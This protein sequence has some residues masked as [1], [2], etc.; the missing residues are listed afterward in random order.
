ML[1]TSTSY[2]GRTTDIPP[3]GSERPTRPFVFSHPRAPVPAMPNTQ[4]LT[5][6]P[7]LLEGMPQ[8]LVDFLLETC[9][10]LATGVAFERVLPLPSGQAMVSLR[11][12]DTQRHVL[13][14]THQGQVVY[15]NATSGFVGYSAPL[16]P[17]T[18]YADRSYPVGA[19]VNAPEAFD[20]LVGFALS[21]P[22]KSDIKHGNNSISYVV[23]NPYTPFPLHVRVDLQR[24]PRTYGP[25]VEHFARN[26]HLSG[27][28]P[29][30]SDR[31]YRDPGWSHEYVRAIDDVLAGRWDDAHFVLTLATSDQPMTV[32][33]PYPQDNPAVDL[34]VTFKDIRGQL[35]L[36]TYTA[37]ARSA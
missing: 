13:A 25:G 8:H 19:Q 12:D 30:D 36:D 37:R 23:P 22:A 4:A 35:T 7:A 27:L 5:L 33:I 20:P 21:C 17:T 31:M 3:L 11:Q 26:V 15:A 1:P 9:A 2:D 18:F 24:V 28:A 10:N 34:L 29:K 14:L 16:V 32:A 6:S